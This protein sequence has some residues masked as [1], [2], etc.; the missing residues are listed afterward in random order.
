MERQRWEESERRKGQKRKSQQKEVQSARKGSKVAKH[1][2]FPM[3]WGSGGSKSRLA[4]AVGAEPSGQ[5][6][7]EKLLHAVVAQRS[8]FRSQNFQNTPRSTFGAL[9][10]LRCSSAKH[11]SKSKCAKCIRSGAVLEAEKPRLPSFAKPLNCSQVKRLSLQD[12]FFGF[13]D[14]EH[15]A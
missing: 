6:R 11:I 5:M 10:T 1:C 13:G 9:W 12:L 2:V 15:K 7:D 8:T 3:R 4:K 14:L